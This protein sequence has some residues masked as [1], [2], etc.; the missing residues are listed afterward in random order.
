[1]PGRK[2]EQVVRGAA[3]VFLRDGFVGASVDDIA[4]AAQVSKA[5]IYSYFP[6][7]VLMFREAM[8]DELARLDGSFTLKIDPDLSPDR[9][10]PQIAL[11][12]AEWLADPHRISLCRVLLADAPRLAELAGGLPDS[13]TRLLRDPV[14]AH[15]DRWADAGLLAIDDTEIAA[16]QLIGLAAANVPLLLMVGPQ[17]ASGATIQA[18][19]SEA[20]ALFLRA[21]APVERQGL[22]RSAGRR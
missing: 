18:T 21:F 20:A 13:L 16:G 15:L 8:R 2:F 7:K 1:M 22:R 17:A 5:T 19:A 9:A 6:D 4:S 3:T 11:Q 12:I 14:R 10:L